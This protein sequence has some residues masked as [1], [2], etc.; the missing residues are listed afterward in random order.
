[1]IRSLMSIVVTITMIINHVAIF[2][3]RHE[4]I[5]LMC[6]KYTSLGYSLYLTFCIRYTSSVSYIELPIVFCTSNTSFIGKICLYKKLH[7]FK[8]QKSAQILCAH[9][10]YFS[11]QVTFIIYSQLYSYCNCLIRAKVCIYVY[12]SL[13]YSIQNLFK[14]SAA[15][16]LLPG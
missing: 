10:P 7:N 12:S 5:G 8:V 16:K 15:P 13:R 9:K 4:K 2:V 3:T 14:F 6:T 11:C 1:M